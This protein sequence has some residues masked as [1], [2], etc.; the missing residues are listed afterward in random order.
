[1]PAPWSTAALTRLPISLMFGPSPATSAR[2]IRTGSWLAPAARSSAPWRRVR[3]GCALALALML[4]S[5]ST[6]ARPP[7]RHQP[8][9]H[10]H[11][12]MPPLQING[13]Q[14]RPL[15]WDAVPGWRDDDQLAA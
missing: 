1:R 8:R 4:A 2:V 6:E 3:A 10:H 9:H 12:A 14:Y 13:A 15:T 5:S 7:H 11:P